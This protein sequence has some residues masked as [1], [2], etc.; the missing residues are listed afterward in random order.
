[1]P[2]PRPLRS[3]D[4]REVAGFRL[5]ARIGEG[6]QGSVFLGESDTGQRVAVKLLH[7]EIGHDD[8]AR[9]LFE[10]ELSAARRVAPFCT[11]RILASGT[12]EDV[13][14]IVSEFI[15]GP[16]LREHITEQGVAGGE[17]LVRLAIGTAT[18]L[19]AI[20]EAGVVHRDFKPANVLLGEDGPRVIDFG[21]A[22]P[23]DATSATMT[24]A[25]GTPAF[26]APE[27]FAGS[28]GGA[29]LDMFAWACTIAFAANGV[30]PFGG[31][32]VAAIMQRVL[33]G[34]PQLG[35]LT[36]ELR[37]LVASCLAKDPAARPTALQV[38]QHLLGNRPDVTRP[39]SPVPRSAPNGNVDLDAAV[40]AGAGADAEA[41]PDARV[42]LL[43]E[44]TSAAA[45]PSPPLP[46]SPMAADAPVP[47][48]LEH[49][50]PGAPPPPGSPPF[51]V[52]QQGTVPGGGPPPLPA[53][54][55]Q[56]MDPAAGRKGRPLLVIAGAA[57]AVLLVTGAVFAA[58][59]LRGNGT[60]TGTGPGAR[61][62]S[63]GAVAQ[64]GPST[65]N[66]VY[67]PTTGTTAKDVGKPP[68]QVPATQPQ[69]ATIKTNLGTLEVQ[70]DPAKAPCT[71]HSLAFLASKKY[72]DN[73][74]CH[75]LTT[76]NTLKVLQCGDPSGS[77]SGG[78]SYQFGNEITAGT[79]YIR[80]TVAMA[81]AGPNTNGSQ[82]F[83]LYGDAPS[84]PPDYTV[85]GR[86]TSGME[87]VDKV[88]KAG[89][90]AGELTGAG[91]G[92]PKQKVT[93]TEFR[94]LAG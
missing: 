35:A 12:D 70:L 76:S 89:A 46:P 63:G 45:S 33:H 27:Q 14:Y 25:V 78:P 56:P 54:F 23:L 5:R 83:I 41:S 17:E 37:A 64:S 34:E 57:A 88:A 75:R 92:P 36:G 30:P 77:G 48:A 52:Y 32:N 91:D 94:T 65:R 28:A 80:G 86:V 19:A 29:P 47:H 13:P 50:W 44:G 71:V 68:S 85:F 51:G 8:R 87:V 79:R 42:S 18:A 38:L 82:F 40:D 59:L 72:Y 11:A 73:T 39:S 61:T 16:S 69:R 49:P 93:I 24:G 90:E 84:L 81:N 53:G 31:D 62:S 15:D 67:S 55:P 2:D 3:N 26:M 21:I 1:M 74:K 6:A 58:V 43:A 60:R 20:H 10:R 9:T 66:C 4:P 7:A 22:R